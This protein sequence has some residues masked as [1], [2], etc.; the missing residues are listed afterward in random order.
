MGFILNL[1]F[2]ILNGFLWNFYYN[3]RTTHASSDGNESS[4]AGYK[5]FKTASTTTSS[6]YGI[7]TRG[8]KPSPTTSNASSY[9][10][11]FI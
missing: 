2:K 1:V 10:I 11:A 5:G 7:H 3:N 4:T 6:S 9:I 8:S